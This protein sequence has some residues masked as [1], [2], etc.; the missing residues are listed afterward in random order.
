M[1][2][3][4]FGALLKAFGVRLGLANRSD[5]IEPCLL[6][7]SFGLARGALGGLGPLA[8]A[9]RRLGGAARVAPPAKVAFDG[10]VEPQP[11]SGLLLA[12]PEVREADLQQL[13]ASLQ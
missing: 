9:L 8:G 3:A 12:L 2:L 11:G 10:P 13:P 5:P 6:R 4:P 1:L 7:L